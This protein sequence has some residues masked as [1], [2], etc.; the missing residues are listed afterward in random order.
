MSFE[1]AHRRDR[2]RRH[3]WQM[4]RTFDLLLDSDIAW[5]R[6]VGFDR[7]CLPECW[8]GCTPRCESS[9]AHVDAYQNR[10]KGTTNSGIGLGGSTV[11]ELRT[12]QLI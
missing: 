9:G 1:E 4:M 7:V 10:I 5:S 6:A 2:G 12:H 8:L 11:A 3:H